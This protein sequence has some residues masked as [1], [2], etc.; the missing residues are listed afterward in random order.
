MDL[1]FFR[2]LDV[3]EIDR[4]LVTLLEIAFGHPP[5][6]LNH[7]DHPPPLQQSLS[8]RSVT[9]VDFAGIVVFELAQ[10]VPDRLF[11]VPWCLRQIQEP[12]VTHHL[13]DKNSMPLLVVTGLQI[14]KHG[15]GIEH[16]HNRAPYRLDTHRVPAVLAQQ[17]RGNL[18]P[19][20]RYRHLPP[21]YPPLPEHRSAYP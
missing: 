10:N 8:I 15:P 4:P 21:D 2:L 19:D 11:V 17:L 14:P 20:A 7:R 3:R 16:L 5:E 12:T 18:E 13:P 6:K 9:L 1:D